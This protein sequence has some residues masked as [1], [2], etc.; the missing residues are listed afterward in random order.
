MMT[1]CPP[2]LRRL[3]EITTELVEWPEHPDFHLPHHLVW[4][5]SRTMF[6]SAQKPILISGAGLS[7]LLLARALLSH[8]I[9]FEVYERDDS[10]YKRAQGYRLRLSAEARS[11]VL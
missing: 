2:S 11:G 5:A 6:T 10:I 8:S 3:T 4:S 1:T 7:S 9:P